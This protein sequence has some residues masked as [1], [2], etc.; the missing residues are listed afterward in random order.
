MLHIHL[1]GFPQVTHQN[2]AVTSFVSNKSRALLF[3]LAATGCPVGR[4]ALAELLW[5]DK[6]ATARG[7]LK[8]ALS[9]LRQLP[10][11]PLL[12]LNDGQVA[13]DTQRCWVDVLDFQRLASATKAANDLDDGHVAAL[14]DASELYRGDFLAGFNLSLSAEFEAWALAEQQRL[15]LL[16]VQLL[17]RLAD[18]YAQRGARSQAVQPLRRLL[19]LEPW[20]EDVHRRLMTLLAQEG[21]RGAALRQFEECRRILREEL[22]VDPAPE[23]I[24]LAMQIR[25]GVLAQEPPNAAT[26]SVHSDTITM[27][28]PPFLSGETPNR[29]L[30]APVV[31]RDD[32]LARLDGLLDRVLAGEGR[33]IF[34]VGDAGSGK[35]ALLEAFGRRSL[36]QNADL[37]VATGHCSAFVAGLGDAYL[38]FREIIALLTG[39][40][41]AGWRAGAIDPDHAQRLW[42]AMP[43]ALRA[44]LAVGPDL[45]DTFLPSAALRKRATQAG[46]Q[47]AA[48]VAQLDDWLARRAASPPRQLL[49]QAALFATYTAVLHALAQHHPLLLVLEDLHWTDDGSLGLL[50]HLGRRLAGERILV[51]GSYRAH[52]LRT[53]TSA[54]PDDAAR[55]HPLEAVVHEMQRLFG[56]AP[57][58]LDRV[59]GRRFV[60]A[61]VDAENNRLSATFRQQLFDRTHGHALFTTEFLRSLRENGALQR[62]V[63]GFWINQGSVDWAQ[64]PLRVEGVIAER[65]DRLPTHLR[66]IVD[67]ACVMGEEFVAEAVARL[68]GQ[69]E[70]ETVRLLGG[71]LERGHQLVHNVGIERV[72]GQRLS[73]YRF[74]HSLFQ[75]FL[76]LALEPAERAYLHEG[77][78]AALETLYQDDV[79]AIALQLARHFVEA[80]RTEKAIHYLAQ[81]G[82]QAIQRHAGQEAVRLFTDALALLRNQPNSQRPTRQVL[83]LT[84]ALAE[85]HWKNN[86]VAESL[87]SYQQAADLATA[88]DAPEALAAAALGYE[89]VRYRFN[90]PA[91]A[92]VRMLSQA[93]ALLGDADNILRVKVT[94]SLVQ[95]LLSTG[96]HERLESQCDDAIAM[97]RR[98]NDPA[99]LFDVLYISAMAFRRPERAQQRVVAA[100]ELMDLAR[101]LDDP[102]RQANVC[103]CRISVNTE[104]GDIES[105]DADLESKMRLAEELG[106]AFYAAVGYTQQTMRA[107][108]AGRFDEVEALA[109]RAIVASQ[110][111][112]FE[113]ADGAY[114]VQM[115]TIRREQDRLRQLSPVIEH[116]VRTNP[117]AAA[118]RPGLALLYADL[119]QEALARQQFETLA[120]NGFASIPRDALWVGSIA[121]L[122]EVC[123]FLGDGTRARTLYDL[124]HPYVGLAVV[125]GFGVVCLGAAD[126][127]LALLASVLQR[128]EVAEAHFEAALA[129][130]TRMHALPWLAHTQFDYAVMLLR[131]G[132]AERRLRASALLDEAQR[133]AADVGMCFL[134]GKVLAVR[135]T[136]ASQEQRRG[137]EG[138]GPRDCQRSESE[139]SD[140]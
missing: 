107:I 55:R 53:E 28:H 94:G 106:Q 29:P 104:V 20:H 49:D 117:Q 96:D 39:D 114:G 36:A 88:L 128:W 111:M 57:L 72:G 35:S 52:D 133:H 120:A 41:E 11:V 65:C 10:S 81:A 15:K 89:F 22:D 63:D 68:L 132:G 33:V 48:E 40:V 50:F 138:S 45:L 127:Y 8:K 43:K 105:V 58:D 23:T 4:D 66:A 32:E 75:H 85:A 124:L 38:P 14:R 125:I 73:R 70:Q 102:E 131:R 116:F 113:N 79:D 93:L 108:L 119:G 95:A 9:N 139:D 136:Q 6:P 112:Q 101:L 110:V 84:L 51:V 31:A 109:Q 69:S 60:E 134:A 1:L 25:S 18:G 47:T 103:G 122:A 27:T 121:Y 130:N 12:D 13:L 129:M 74:R 86:Q 99:A 24:A 30:P 19:E 21:D 17:Q 100:N 118:W 7:N 34:V 123:A 80:Q 62:D 44:T 78:G 76:Y 98:L 91:D 126:R 37:L 46:S 59:D 54:S 83:D 135:Q 56:E 92:A 42:R 2:T 87:H 64:T 71:A 90:L 16:A 5:A 137:A 77:V 67:V 140:R 61:I 26:G 3:H 97:A 82:Q 115:F